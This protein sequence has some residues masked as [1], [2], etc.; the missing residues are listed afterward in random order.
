MFFLEFAANAENLREEDES[1]AKENA[2]E[3]NSVVGLRLPSGVFEEVE[4]QGALE[5]DAGVGTERRDNQKDANDQKEGDFLLGEDVAAFGTAVERDEGDDHKY[6][7]GD[8]ASNLDDLESNNPI[9]AGIV[10]NGFVAGVEIHVE[11]ADV[12]MGSYA[13]GSVLYWVFGIIESAACIEV[14]DSE[15]IVGVAGSDAA[16]LWGVFA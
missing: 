15:S 3:M 12:R 11:M 2:G 13:V 8:E 6:E 10:A 4:G 16:Y 14:G 1:Q 9:D 5:V 7:D